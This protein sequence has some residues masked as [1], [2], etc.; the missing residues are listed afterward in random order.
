L[1]TNQ[2]PTTPDTPLGLRAE[3]ATRL[4]AEHGQNALPEAAS[5]PLWRRFL[6][7]LRSPLIYIL[8]F[9][10]AFD[11]AFWAYERWA[12]WPIEGFVIAAVLLLNAGL[13]TFQE[14]RSEQ[15]AGA[16]PGAHS[17]DVWVMRDG[18]LVQI[19]SRRSRTRRCRAHRGRRA[20]PGRRGAA[21]RAWA[22]MADEAVLTGESIPVD[23]PVGEELQSGTLVLA[24]KGMFRVTETGKKSAMGKI[25]MML[26]EI[27]PEQTPLERRLGKSRQSARPLDL[28]LVVLLIVAGIATEGIARIDR[29]VMFA[30]ALAVAAIPEGMPAVVTLTL[31]LGVQRMA[32]R[33]ALCAGSAP[34]RRWAPSR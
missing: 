22:I 29:V 11:F 8:L 26:G 1:S 4:L 15:G 25:A 18:K 28:R 27:V 20:D 19:P 16:A 30:V 7:Q 5:V 3:E 12:G 31:A 24:G 9:A 32:R 33:T 14:Y 13:G 6:R 21:S 10:V 17:P 34:W 23:K 2:P